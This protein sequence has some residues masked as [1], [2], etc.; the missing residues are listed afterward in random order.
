[1]TT[2]DEDER[3]GASALLER[4]PL[5]DYLTYRLS[6]VQAKLNAQG[7]KVLRD[8]AGLTLVQWRVVAFIGA[9]GRSSLSSI[10]RETALDKGLLSR[11]LKTLVDM[12]VVRSEQ[13]VVD[14]R[15]QHLSLTRRGQD[16]F[17][18]ALPVTKRRQAWLRKDLTA[19]EIDTFKRV[20]LKLERASQKLDF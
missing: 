8:A 2:A 3:P 16:L 18:R 5:Q 19:A 4:L 7:S 11:N 12:G 13:D 10:T 20:L 1:M 15:V 14:N 17:E 9:A 6:R